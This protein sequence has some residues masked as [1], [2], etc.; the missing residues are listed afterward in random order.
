MKVTELRDDGGDRGPVV[1]HRHVTV[2][3]ST[4][5]QTRSWV[6]RAVEL[7]AADR[8]V[9]VATVVVR[10][11]ELPGYDP[12]LA[13]TAAARDGALARCARAMTERKAARAEVTRAIHERERVTAELEAVALGNGPAREAIAAH[14]AERARLEAELDSTRS[15]CAASEAALT[16]AVDRHADLQ[17]L[18]AVAAET[19]DAAT[20]RRRS[21][22]QDAMDAAA[23]LESARSL[24]APG[25]D[26]VAERDA[27]RKHLADAEREADV[28]D[29]DGD[30]SPL[31]QRLADLERQRIELTRR[32]LATGNSA[33]G[34]VE[35]AMTALTKG[36]EDA[37]AMVAALALADTW[38]DLHQQIDALDSG[39]SQEERAAD[40]DLAT[41]CRHLAEIEIVA[42]QPLLTPEQVAKVEAAHHAVLE[43][44]ERSDA[45]FGGGRA[46]KRL[47]E[48]RSDERRVLERLGLSTYADY[49][50]S[51]SSRDRSVGKRSVDAARAEIDAAQERLD[52]IPGSSD[53]A[54]RRN[55]LLE[56][57]DTVA[58]KITALLGYD[59]AGPEAEGELRLLRE[60]VAEEP[61]LLDG[62]AGALASAGIDVGPGPHDRSDLIV[63]A[64]VYIAEDHCAGTERHGL[65]QAIEAVDA[66]VS[67]LRAA[68][69]RGE[70]EV[71][72]DVDLPAVGERFDA[73]HDA[74]HTLREAR[75][76]EVEAARTAV[77]EADA[78]VVRHAGLTE[79]LAALQLA[80]DDAGRREQAAAE[81][82]TAAEAAAV[83]D[84]SSIEAA[85]SAVA[86]AQTTL[87]R[88]R[89][90]LA[91]AETAV[92][93]V[94]GTGS[95]DVV[96]ATEA[97]L[98][99]AEN[100]VT[101]AGVAEQ[102]AADAM[103][104]AEANLQSATDVAEVAATSRADHDR[105]ALVDDVDWELLNRLAGVRPPDG[106]EPLPLVLDDPFEVVGD[107]EVAGVLDRLSRFAP[108]AQIVVISNRSA[109]ADW[110]SSAGPERA[111]IVAA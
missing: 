47:E 100:L 58:P 6:L 55:E 21:A 91:A 110:A 27:A 45:R 48:L 49:M 102:A 80:M 73:D 26:P 59:P 30:V 98:S 44:Q 77:T 105:D 14:Q 101:Q 28:A 13:E 79:E 60:P 42:N 37:P 17:N 24:T 12:M 95:E 75:W 38:R 9:P 103:E 41:A 62:L 76:A 84:G 87:A 5:D 8:S 18:S 43:A 67:D 68:R 88:H 22:V 29:P 35:V 71:P 40:A 33:G 63:L 15:Q 74:D 54:R 66:A 89:T 94:D 90:A 11:E 104:L 25:H 108:L 57:R 50:M 83:G 106:S 7:I 92:A 51:S 64:R 56:R 82:L 2:V 20:A 93:A 86:A 96:A 65:H 52:A 85:A 99:A 81:E 111:S 109:V 19:V 78:R 69:D 3:Q 10:S 107:D 31:N 97:A 46:R 34:A 39:V 61:A 53:R 36:T 72:D 32:V 70:V 1:L 16:D 4:D 23:A